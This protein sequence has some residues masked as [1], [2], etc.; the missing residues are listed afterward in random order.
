[1][2][3]SSKQGKEGKNEKI[4]DK[5]RVDKGQVLARIIIEVLGAPKEY[6]E[7]AIQLVIDKVHKTKDVEVVSEST[8]EAEEK[9]K[10]FSTFSEIEIWFK[11]VDTL[12]RFLF[13]FTPSS[14]EI[15]QPIKLH[16]S[17]NFVSGFLNDFLL[18]MHDL[19][20]K[21]KDNAAK[22]Q[23]LQKNTD[24]LVR[25]FMHF[26][27]REPRSV[28]EIAK[29]TGIPKPNAEAMLANFEKAGVVK[30]EN[31]LFVITKKK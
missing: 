10:L 26:V 28:D 9:G 29:L 25:N 22:T 31:G 20:L 23:L 7:E 15:M 3:K 21:L 11:D 8:F 17:A 5:E 16:L 4:S 30:K 6:V 12:S 19:G 1:M 13:D 27:L 18:K 14:V 24:V 2:P